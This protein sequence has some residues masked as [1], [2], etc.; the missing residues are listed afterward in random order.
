M[1][2]IKLVSLVIG[3]VLASVVTFVGVAHAQSFKTGNNVGVTAG[4]T[5]NSMLFAAG[6]NVD[7]AGTVNGD[8]YCA[9]QTVTISGTVNGDVFCAGQT[10]T[11]SGK[12]D[13]SVRLAGQTVTLG[14]TVTNSAT[15]AAQD[16]VM[17]KSATIG[18]DLLGGTTNATINGNVARDVT[19]GVQNLTVNGSVGRDITS[20]VETL[21]I[22]AT[23]KV[24]GNV[25]YT[26]NNQLTVAS[27]GVVTGTVARTEPKA[28]QSYQMRPETA[29]TIAIVS[30][31]VAII[32]TIVF[33]LAMA[34]MFPKI[35]ENSTLSTIASPGKTVLTGLIAVCVVPVSIFILFVTVIGIPLGIFAL[36][37]WGIIVGLSVPFSSYLL[38][39]LTMQ[40]SKSPL[41]VM[42]V[43]VS[44]IAVALFIP[45]INLFIGIA[46][47]LFGIG[48][49][50]MQAKK[51]FERPHFKKAA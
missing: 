49:V 15:I 18:R 3:L 8:V 27:G 31:I 46:V 10:I 36:L 41:L 45:L 12:V 38:G 30:A 48:A 51:L 19:A 20:Y 32:A 35:L 21:N 44:I 4:E 34:L 43:G 6:N 40:K 39:K 14:G 23:A 47:G 29:L 22:G 26:S 16:F 17:D 33:A 13:G 9:G 2:K 28:N 25:M 42:L 7:I 11:I 50:L 5:V 37:S 1:K 24:T